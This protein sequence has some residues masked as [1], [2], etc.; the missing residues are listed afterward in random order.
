MFF[1]VEIIEYLDGCRNNWNILECYWNIPTLLLEVFL[2]M[3]EYN[4]IFFYSVLKC[5]VD[6]RIEVFRWVQSRVARLIFYKWLAS[7]VKYVRSMELS[8]FS[9][10]FFFP[11]KL[12][13]RVNVKCKTKVDY[14]KFFSDRRYGFLLQKQ[15]SCVSIWK[16]SETLLRSKTIS[17]KFLKK[18]N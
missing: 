11:I 10:S 1:R 18:F 8:F 5:L 14:L 17:L 16:K 15:L 13:C 9:I 7:N 3:L 4:W 2:V 6:R 12:I